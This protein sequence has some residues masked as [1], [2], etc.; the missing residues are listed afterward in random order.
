[1][2]DLAK[3]REK[4][5]KE[6]QKEQEQKVSMAKG[7]PK[8]ALPKEGPS[9]ETALDFTKTEM[10]ASME[11]GKAAVAPEAALVVEEP[12]SKT[13]EERL[14]GP[15]PVP[16]EAAPEEAKPAVPPTPPP[17]Q[18]DLPRQVEGLSTEAEPGP[19]ERPEEKEAAP[20]P[21]A[22]VLWRCLTFEVGSELYGIPIEHIDEIIP[23]QPVTDVP[24]VPSV[25]TGIMSLRGRIVTVIDSR[26]RLGHPVRPPTE[27]AR[28]V[29]LAQQGELFGLWVDGVKQVIS[30]PEE[31]IEETT[32]MVA[33]TQNPYLRG[34]Y[35]SERDMV[36]L[37]D[38]ERF[39]DI[40]LA[41]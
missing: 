35:H 33:A 8:G 40:R 19:G 23:V 12:A 1:M 27:E 7:P 11:S 34:V 5:R 22:P 16:G 39:L 29:V 37:L 13:T 25:V 9:E 14:P 26:E 21:A 32:G 15:P 31:S 28:I 36:I 20:S 4:A 24:N 2:V 6:K 38:L 41:S 30:V 3:A 17:A 18:A 10:E